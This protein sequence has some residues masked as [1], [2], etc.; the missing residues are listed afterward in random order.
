MYHLEPS[1]VRKIAWSYV[2]F[3]YSFSE[4]GELSLGIGR[5]V[6]FAGSPD[7]F[8]VQAMMKPEF[9][10]LPLQ[11]RFQ[12][13]KV[14]SE[15]RVVNRAAIVVEKDIEFVK[16]KFKFMVTGICDIIVFISCFQ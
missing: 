10:E 16:S 13:K 9:R 7:K 1:V 3:V 14:A 15:Q 11:G 5:V 6:P 8:M 4:K 12:L 2:A